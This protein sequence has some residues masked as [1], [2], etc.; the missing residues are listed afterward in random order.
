MIFIDNKR[1]DE[2]KQYLLAHKIKN[3]KDSI[4]IDPSINEKGR[5][6]YDD[7]GLADIVLGYIYQECSRD[8]SIANVDFQSMNHDQIMPYIEK[9]VREAAALDYYYVNEKDWGGL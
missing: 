2:H 8:Y 9:A 4:D 7:K 6:Y 1:F 3:C 5:R